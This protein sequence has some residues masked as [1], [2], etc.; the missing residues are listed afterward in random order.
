MAAHSEEIAATHRPLDAVRADAAA[1]GWSA[2]VLAHLL[3]ASPAE[4][5]SRLAA[6]FHRLRGDLLLR[7]DSA[8]PSRRRSRRGAIPWPRASRPSR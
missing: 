7:P 8:P 6:N 2:G 1:Q 5:Q 4:L 3:P